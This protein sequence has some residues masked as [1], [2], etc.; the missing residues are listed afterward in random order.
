[1]KRPIRSSF[2][3]AAAG[4]CCWAAHAA[5]NDTVFACTAADGSVYL[6]NEASADKCV[7]VGATAPATEAAAPA[8]EAAAPAT[9]AAAVSADQAEPAGSG[10][11][12]AGAT[13]KV[14]RLRA[15]RAAGATDDALPPLETRLSNYRDLMVQ[16]A[17]GE[18]GSVPAAASNPAVNRRY[19][20]M[21]KATFMS[22][23]Q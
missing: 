19:L 6:T 20:K 7:P 2:W 5:A 11:A 15:A 12:S 4:F 9:E 3:L 18:A 8:T 10:A 22:G 16:G 14:D 23:Q 13:A 1:M 21:D 17:S